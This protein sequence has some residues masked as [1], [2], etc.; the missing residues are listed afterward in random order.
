MSDRFK[1][2]IVRAKGGKLMAIAERGV[3]IPIVWRSLRLELRAQSRG[4]KQ[5]GFDEKSR[6]GVRSLSG[7]HVRKWLVLATAL[8]FHCLRKKEL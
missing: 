6:L 3:G 4:R 2:I 8:W 5:G 7:L 1:I